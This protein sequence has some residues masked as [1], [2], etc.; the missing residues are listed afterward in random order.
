MPVLRVNDRQHA[1]KPGRTRLGGGADVDVPVSADDRLGEQAIIDM[2]ELQVVIRRTGYAP[3]K[4]NGVALG[5]EPTP[6]MHGDKVEIAGQELLYAEDGKVGA[7]QFVTRDDVATMVPKRPAGARPTTGTGGRLVSLVDGK[8]YSVPA[9]G[10]TIGRDASSDVVV[11]QNEVS[12]RHA[13]ILPTERGYVLYDHS[14]NGVYVNGTRVQQTQLLAR[15]DVVRVGTDEFRFYADVTATVPAVA[16]ASAAAPLRPAPSAPAPATPP[17]SE[18]P[19][20]P[21]P[22]AVGAR[23]EAGGVGSTPGAGGVATERVSAVPDNVASP[24]P[25]QPSPAE[26]P[27]L[28]SLE[29]VSEGVNKGKR[30][31]VRVPLAHVGRG[32]HNDIAIDDDSVSDTHA[33]LQRRDDGWYL[34][35]LASTNGTYVGGSRI[36]NERRLDGMPDLRFGGVKLTFRV[37]EGAPGT[38]VGK[39]TR[40]IATMAVDRTKARREPKTLVPGRPAPAEVARTGGT[41]VWIWLLILVAAVGA[42]FY[43]MKG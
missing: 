21:P 18:R 43:L 19:I 33:K 3:V 31:D 26:R 17:A 10:V 22:D 16:P 25:A 34:V 24:P 5:M 11:A 38:P 27:V 8:E 41:S 37:A 7:T 9:K 2:N 15:S 35:D 13:E 28:A 39:G 12:R 42:A 6:L 1:L 30:F 23:S 40:A 36:S 14:T 29:V 32:A 20:P 4:V